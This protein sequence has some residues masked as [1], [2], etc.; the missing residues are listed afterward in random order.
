MKKIRA[1][2]CAEHGEPDVLEIKMV[3][4]PSPGPEDLLIRVRACGVNFPDVL[5]LRGQ[6]QVK[7]QL[8]FSPGFEVAGE[9][10]EA[11]S[12]VTDFFVGD[13]IIAMLT[14][15]GMQEQVVAPAKRCLRI[16]KS[17][18]F[19]VAA[20]FSL[21]YGTSYHALI[22]RAR[23]RS[24]ETL[25]VLGAA[26]G[27]G[28]A[29]IDIGRQLGARV[30][31]AGS[32]EKKLSQLQKIYGVDETLMYSKDSLNLRDQV[33]TMTNGVGVDV[34]FDPVGGAAFQQAMRCVNWNGR[35]LVV[36]FA[37]DSENLPK[38]AT[39]LLLLKGSAL[40]GVFWGRFVEEEPENSNAN[41]KQLISWYE[42]GRIKPTI[43]R[44]FNLDE[45]AQALTAL[46]DRQ[47]VGK[48]VVVL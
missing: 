8:P 9:V 25:L 34:I 26:G 3:N 32:D 48:C 27:V 12:E 1:L 35:I 38:A 24:G 30:I 41:F 44:H 4:T 47:V 16:P 37:S 14:S 40:V 13:R 29:A 15:G 31:A 39:N 6:Y 18:A 2:V 19:D 23:L 7:P 36:G 42:E 45:G 21:T 17:M 11:G 22:D 28:S 33:K 46:I 5:M 20:G 43:W 10:L